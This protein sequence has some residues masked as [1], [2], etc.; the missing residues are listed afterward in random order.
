MPDTQRA[1]RTVRFGPFQVSLETGELRRKGLKVRLQDHPFRVLALLIE[2]PGQVVTRQELR[3]AIWPKD[4]FVDFDEGVDAAIYRLRRALGDSGDNPQY[5]ETLARRGYRFIGSI[6]P[7]FE[8]PSARATIPGENAQAAILPLATIGAKL[9]QA[10]QSSSA[11]ADARLFTKRATA[12]HPSW[13]KGLL[14]AAVLVIVTGGVS[15]QP[16]PQPRQYAIAVL[17]FQNL[18]SDPN[19]DYFSDGLT[20]EIITDLSEIEGLQVKSQT[21]S[22]AFKN[23]HLD[24]PEV[25][26]QLGVDL[27]LEGSVLRSAGRLR[28]DV[29]LVRVADDSTLWSQGYDRELK[30]IFEVQDEISRSIVNELR[31]KHV[32]GQRRYNTNLEAYDLYLRAQSLSNGDSQEES[33]LPGAIA[34]Y[35]QVIAKDPDFAP[36]YAS[37]ADV[38]AHLRSS[39]QAAVVPEADQQMRAAAEKAIQL[40]PLLAEAYAAMGLVYSSDLAWNDAERSFQ[41]ALQ[42]N[43]NLPRVRESYAFNV[44]LP[45]GRVGEAVEQYRAAVTLDPL[46]ALP[47]SLL[48]FGLINAGA[49]D[50]A[51]RICRRLIATYPSDDFARWDY[52]RALWF[53]GGH[54]EAISVLE[55]LGPYDHGFLGYEYGR[56]GR[57]GDA[58]RLASEKDPN[59]TRHQVMIYAGL[60]EKDRVMEALQRLAAMHDQFVDIYP[61]FPELALMRDDP[62]MKEFRHQRGLPWPP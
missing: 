35:R 60:G 9:G 33:E 52:A 13:R 25:G 19:S 44:L 34:L 1:A 8:G 48:A 51:L 7:P 26:R 14:V 39:R 59:I 30:D 23:K 4:T 15:W 36:A 31:L 42:L 18:S 40:D 38:Y 61:L 5:I 49:Y 46:S 62:R 6:I 2:R 45:E 41:R 11:I 22:F 10:Q 50:E 21:S 37:L 54:A 17:P 27:L 47:R 28:V 3:E 56:I 12:L 58:E 24:V 32:G 43:P 16:R 55:R 29:N 53:K 57:R 20:D